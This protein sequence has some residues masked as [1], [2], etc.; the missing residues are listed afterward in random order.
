MLP[1]EDPQDDRQ[2]SGEDPFE[3]LGLRQEEFAE[4]ALNGPLDW[5]GEQM[6]NLQ[7]LLE[8][9]PVEP[10]ATRALVEDFIHYIPQTKDKPRDTRD[11]PSSIPK[12]MMDPEELAEEMAGTQGYFEPVQ[13][14]P[15]PAMDVPSSRVDLDD[16]I[17]KK[18]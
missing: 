11:R 17:R 16:W 10:E 3:E 18:S 12:E 9:D 4:I 7:A 15:L 14:H 5:D 13:F 2:R 1:D 6:D 8:G